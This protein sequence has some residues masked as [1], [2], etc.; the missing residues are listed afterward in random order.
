MCT[1]TGARCP[2]RQPPTDGIGQLGKP[3]MSS[4]VSS[5]A[6]CLLG[7][8]SALSYQ[9]GLSVFTVW[10]LHWFYAVSG[11]RV[12]RRPQF[13]CTVRKWTKLSFSLSFAQT[14]ELPPKNSVFDVDREPPQWVLLK[15]RHG[16]QELFHSVSGLFTSPR[17]HLRTL[18]QC[19][20]A[21]H[22]GISVCGEDRNK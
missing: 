16:F 17:S 13:L 3:V 7:S 2:P 6:E 15:G 8:G 5:A 10:K 11:K 9:R 21:W 4:E 18:Q 1:H 19:S 12:P 20:F 22:M 14:H